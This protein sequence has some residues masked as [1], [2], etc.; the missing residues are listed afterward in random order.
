MKPTTST[1]ILVAG[2]GPAGMGA[3]LALSKA[4]FEVTVAAPENTRPD[5]RT[6]TLMMPSIRFLDNLGVWDAVKPGAEPLSTMRVVDGTSRLVRART[7]S[8]EAAEIGEVAFGWNM[9]NMQL[10]AS[11]LDEIKSRSSIKTI[12]LAVKDYEFSSNAI[13]AKLADESTVCAK[14][15]VGADGRNSPARKAAGVEVRNWTYPQTA[16]ITVFDHRLPHE[17]IS[18]EFHTEQGPCVQVPL[19]GNRSSLVWVVRPEKAEELMAMGD[20]ALSRAIEDR[21]ASILGKVTV[22]ANR[23]AY[24]LSGQY[25][26]SFARN[27]IA[28]VGEAAHVFPPIGAQGLNLGLRD[29]EDLVKATISNSI[30]PGA[31][32]VLSA[33]NRTRRPDITARTG[34]VDALNR[35]LL[36]SHLPAQ[37]ARATGMAFLDMAAPLRGLFMREGMKPGEGFRALASDIREGIRRKIPLGNG[38]E[39]R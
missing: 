25:P 33:Y 13:T 19:P 18:T 31:D 6:T 1:E 16:F 29:V 8:F 4:G 2:N 9:P 22:G 12:D 10:N 35:A 14:L 36:S 11:L 15:V 20:A 32:T 21:I 26:L 39:K 38:I 7:V 23:Q 37:V 27:R 3:A 5:H 30:D 28:L 34:A 24:P 17:G